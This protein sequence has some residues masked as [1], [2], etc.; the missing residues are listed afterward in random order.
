MIT[1]SLLLIWKKDIF[2]KLKNKRPDGEE[3]ERT[4]EIMKFCNTKD[5]EKLTKLYCKTDVTLLADVFEKFVRVTIKEYGINP[6]FC[7]KLPG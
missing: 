7:V 4:K 2:S 3:T 6:R 1:K 5:G